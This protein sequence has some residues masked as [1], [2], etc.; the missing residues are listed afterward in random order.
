MLDTYAPLKGIDKYKVRFNS[1]DNLGFTK[2]N[3]SKIN[4]N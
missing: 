1:K 2:I 4:S 3:T